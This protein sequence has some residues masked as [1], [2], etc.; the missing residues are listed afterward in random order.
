MT[1][2]MGANTTLETSKARR[3]HQD[4]LAMSANRTTVI[5][6][7]QST[8][9]PNEVYIGR[10]TRWGNPFRIGRDGSRKEVVAK[11]RQY[12]TARAEMLA[13]LHELVGK[14]LVCHCH[15]R[16]CHGDV[17][18]ELANEIGERNHEHH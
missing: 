5:H 9:D 11:Y 6:I 7:S 3:Q 17:L 2:T 15:P 4:D 18:A 13:D 1:L 14:V 10:P 12:V 16:P 8:G